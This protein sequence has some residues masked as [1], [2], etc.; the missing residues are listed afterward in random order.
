VYTWHIHIQGI[1]QGVDFRPFV[2]Q[3]AHSS[4]INGWVDN[5]MDGVHIEFSCGEDRPITFMPKYFFDKKKE[6]LILF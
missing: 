3:L 4:G 2:Y 5:D 1:V 6:Q